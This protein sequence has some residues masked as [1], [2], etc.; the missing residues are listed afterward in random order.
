MTLHESCRRIEGFRRGKSGQKLGGGGDKRDYRRQPYASLRE[1]KA[2][3]ALALSLLFVLAPGTILQ[4][5]SGRHETE[6]FVSTATAGRGS[7]RG[8]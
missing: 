5:Y 8:R 7:G 6:M 3:I 2:G 1:A 4:L